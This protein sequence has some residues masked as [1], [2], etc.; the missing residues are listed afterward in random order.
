MSKKSLEK[1]FQYADSVNVAELLDDDKLIEVAKDIMAGFEEDE[2]SS[3]EWRDNAEE[4]LELTKLEREVKNYPMPNASNVKY[5]LITV[6]ALQFT[7]RTLPEL[8]KSGEV[9]KYKIIG[10]DRQGAKDR[11][12]KRLKAHLNY[13]IMEIME[14]WLDSRDRLLMHLAVVGTVFTKTYFDPI[15][16]IPKSVFIPYDEIIINNSIS[17]LEE[18]DRV[19]H[20]LYLSERELIEHQRFGLFRELPEES[21]E[22]DESD[23]INPQELL[24]VH[25]YLDLDL[26]G[27][28]EPYVVTMHRSSEYILRIAPRYVQESILVNADDEVMKIFGKNF[29]SDYHLIH[30]PAG[31]FLSLGFGTLLLDM[32]MT[33]NTV[34]NQL[35]D[36]GKLA[37]L[38][39]GFIGAGLRM[40]AKTVDLEP[41]EW[42]PME[43]ADGVSLKQNIVPLAYKEPSLVLFQLLGT[44]IDAAKELT[45]TTEALTGN[46]ETQNVSPNT[47]MALINQGL[48]VFAAIQR[49]V[50]RG[51]KKEFMKI[52]DINKIHLDPKEYIE[53]IDPDIPE[54]QE[55]VDEQGNIIDYQQAGTD[56]V[57]V[58]DVH[59][60]TEAERMAKLQ[61]ELSGG[62]QLAQ[63]GGANPQGLAFNYFTG[64][65]SENMENLVAPPP[66]QGPDKELLELQSQIDKTGKELEMKD[67]ELQLKL[68]E[69]DAKTTKMH[70]DAIKAIAE[71]E[72]AEVGSQVSQYDAIVRGLAE[73]NK[74]LTE[75]QKLNEQQAGASSDE[76]AEGSTQSKSE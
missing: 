27:Y 29:F 37:N 36:S 21:I 52:V 4:A 22:E 7:S 54:L 61:A 53:I 72:A 48:K 10:K 3:Q 20:L 71:A 17:S 41:G 73:S 60:S 45:S 23:T 75:R 13:Q 49:R 35:L 38:Q 39:G 50:F 55:M 57:P 64:L 56:V 69:I 42:L 15:E 24:E 31:G 70:A 5:P 44:L 34:M 2:R 16:G 32:N 58:A 66:Q 26:D 46:S 65:E 30:D 40:R 12:G 33:V 19:T 18:A 51:Y 9:A 62:L 68:M 59:G 6:A 28:P 8:I 74:A 1:L 47:L 43:A 76:T 63:I 14:D 11:R 67:K 25:C